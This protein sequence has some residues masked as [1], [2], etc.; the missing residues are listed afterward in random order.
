[1]CKQITPISPPPGKSIINSIGWSITCIHPSPQ[2]LSHFIYHWNAVTAGGKYTKPLHNRAEEAKNCC[3]RGICKCFLSWTSSAK[4]QKV[5]VQICAFSPDRILQWSQRSI[6][7]VSGG[8]SITLQLFHKHY[9]TF[10]WPAVMER[11]RRVW[12]CFPTHLSRA[13]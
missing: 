3:C 9:S 1:M 12:A 11:R 6:T 2:Y 8:W 13:I 4:S 5:L 7:T 10:Y